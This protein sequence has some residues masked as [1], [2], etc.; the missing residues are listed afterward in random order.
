MKSLPNRSAYTLRCFLF[1]DVLCGLSARVA[2]TV[3]ADICSRAGGHLHNHAHGHPRNRAGG[4]YNAAALPAQNIIQTH[5]RVVDHE[6]RVGSD[7]YDDS[8]EC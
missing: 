3:P 7:I 4:L 2:P 5:N 1:V 8:S 6:V